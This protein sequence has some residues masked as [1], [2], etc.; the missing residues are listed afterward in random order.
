[1]SI[2]P[3]NAVR[4]C[5]PVRSVDVDVRREPW[6][7]RIART[8][9]RHRDA[10]RNTLYDLGKVSGCVVRRQKRELCP[11]RA[12]H[13]RH[14]SL[15]DAIVVSVDLKLD[16][17]AGTNLGE[18]GLL[19]VRGDPDPGVSDDAEQRL[20][21]RDKLNHLHPLSRNP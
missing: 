14:F 10:H 19:E 4:P 6:S 2:S 17:L 21:P 3:T 18:L 11:G 8:W 1:M 13:T 12:A 15:A 9:L 16:R 7:Q 5:S 20:A